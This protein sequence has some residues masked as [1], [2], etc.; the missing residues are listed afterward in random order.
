MADLRTLFEDL[1]YR[2]VRTLLNNE[3][4][5][6]EALAL[7]RRTA[8]LWCA[9]GI[10]KSDLWAAANRVVG[11]GGAARNLATMTKLLAL[12]EVP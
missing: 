3:R 4:W 11:N 6:P 1:G 12:V 7:R 10:A 8:Y 5:A 2:D 9:H